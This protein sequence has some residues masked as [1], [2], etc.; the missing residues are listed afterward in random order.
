MA[1]VKRA[2]TL[3][4]IM[5]VVALMVA[6]GSISAPIY[7]SFQVK[8]NL[9]I[10]AYTITQ[11]L[12]RAQI[13]SQAGAGDAIW[14]VQ[15]ANGSVTLF[16]SNDATLNEVSEISSNISV[17][18]AGISS[19]AY[20]KLSGEPQTAGNIILTTSNNDTAT[21]TINAKGTIEY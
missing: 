13:L 20:A 6:V 18:P 16:N 21:I 14:G 15:I 7:Q 12:R 17:S 1:Q 19:V 5:L 2:F 4:E 8:N 11:T 3:I 9:D 10:A